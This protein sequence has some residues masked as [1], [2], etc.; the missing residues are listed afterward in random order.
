MQRDQKKKVQ[1][2]FTKDQVKKRPLPVKNVERLQEP[3]TGYSTVRLYRHGRIFCGVTPNAGSPKRLKH[4]KSS[5]GA[6]ES[7]LGTGE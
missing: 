2:H 6:P 3:I 1:V 5:N 4:G 7:S